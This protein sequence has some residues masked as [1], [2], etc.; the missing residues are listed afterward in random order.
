[1]TAC[2]AISILKQSRLVNY[3]YQHYCSDRYYYYYY[4][5]QHCFSFHWYCHY[6]STGNWPSNAGTTITES[7]TEY[8]YYQYQHYFSHYNNNNTI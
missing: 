4:H 1:M 5:Y 7:V 6:Y 2:N 3:S 8:C